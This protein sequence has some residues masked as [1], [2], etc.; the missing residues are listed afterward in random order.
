MYVMRNQ[1]R[2]RETKKK[3]VFTFELNVKTRSLCAR[4]S[5]RLSQIN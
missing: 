4:V 2:K 5:Q 3:Q 1:K